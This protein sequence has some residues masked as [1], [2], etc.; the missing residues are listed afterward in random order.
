MILLVSFIFYPLLFIFILTIRLCITVFMSGI[1]VESG[2]SF[3]KLDDL[4]WW[5]VTLGYP[6]LGFVDLNWI[7]V[8][9]RFLF[10]KEFRSK[11]QMELYRIFNRFLGV[12]NF[13]KSCRVGRVGIL[14]FQIGY[15]IVIPCGF[16]IGFWGQ[17]LRVDFQIG[18]WY[19]MYVWWLHKI[20]WNVEYTLRF[21]NEF[22][23]ETLVDW[24]RQIRLVARFNPF[25][26][27]LS[28]YSKFT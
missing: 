13:K 9:N 2:L 8:I 24:V 7:C 28:V 27:T 4:L 16:L 14:V 20:N 15:D 1:A 23:N 3:F 25:F 18:T 22:Y 21:K 17:L 19:S 26:F 5:F 12:K 10:D 6:I 11:I